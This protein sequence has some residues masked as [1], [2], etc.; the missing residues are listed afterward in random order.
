MS[1]IKIKH[2]S[3][4]G[5]GY[6]ENDGWMDIKRVTAFTGNQGSGKN[7][8]A[9]LISTFTWIE[10]SLFRGDHDIKWYERKNR[11]KNQLFSYHRIQD[12]FRING[13]D[14]SILEYQGDAYT[15]KYEKGSVSIK[16]GRGTS[17]PLPQIMYVPAERNFITYV[18]SPKE[19]KLSSDS[20]KEFLTE[21]ENAKQETKTPIKLPINNSTIEYNKVKDILN[22]KGENYKIKLT[23]ASSGFQSLVPLFMV[24][25][26]LANS[27]KL[28]SETS[29]NPMSVE[30]KERFRKGVKDIYDNGALTL[31]QKRDAISELSR[32][33][34][35]S[36]FINI[37]E[38]PEQNLFPSSQWQMLKAL[39]KFN[40]M[41][42]GNK[43]I[44]T[45]H[46]PYII[47]FISIVIQADYLKNEIEKA[48]K[49]A[50]LD[51]LCKIVPEESMTNAEKVVIYELDEQTG[52]IHK[53][54]SL[55]GIPSDDN[56]LN[57]MLAEGNRIFD[58][59]LEIEQKL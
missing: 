17:Y 5:E 48:G 19:L 3:P 56:Y 43:L 24:S 2:F 18:N 29:Q 25:R 11:L 53:L 38:E 7:T 49:T 28:Q 6:V 15:I 23:E 22:L 59:L 35:K 44:M 33:F 1:K 31:E 21:F 52:T 57:K 12:Y 9:K 42:E 58:E 51:S 39:L 37:V 47:N 16:E 32:R 54:P 13:N 27:V 40:N 4:F 14:K 41:N 34:N 50:L 26:Y 30:E 20:L 8:V 36:S 10:K 45:T 55:N 46:S